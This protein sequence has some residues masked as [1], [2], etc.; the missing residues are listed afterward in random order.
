[1]SQDSG[2][3]VTAA[4]RIRHAKDAILSQWEA[5]ARSELPHARQQDRLTLHDEL[6]EF[7]EEMAKALETPQ[8]SACDNSDVCKSHGIQRAK[9]PEYDFAEIHREYDILRRTILN[10]LEKD[11]PI[12]YEERNCILNSIFAAV[13]QSG[14]TFFKYQMKK[15]RDSA[16]RLREEQALREQFVATLTHDLRSPLTAARAAAHIIMQQGDDVQLRHRAVARLNSAIDRADRMIRDLLDANQIR[17][18]KPL[19]L[20]L[21]E[22]ELCRLVREIVADFTSIHGDRFNVTC[23]PPVS[24]F[25]SPLDIQRALINLLDNAVK[26]GWHHTI[27]DVVVRSTAD[28]AVIEVSNKGPSVPAGDLARLFDPFFRT[29]AAEAAHKG[30]WGLGLT[31]VRGVAEAHGGRVEARGASDGVT[32]SISLPRDAR[33]SNHSH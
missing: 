33:N 4:D 19:K 6:P 29:Q 5:Q 25:W 27:V 9:L 26:Y 15:E 21:S 2:T 8:T 14:D 16:D 22:T 31:I 24:G 1:M 23:N 30:G 18:G 32:F 10:V 11:N 17:A 3:T 12:S 13:R 20:H 7:L 28:E